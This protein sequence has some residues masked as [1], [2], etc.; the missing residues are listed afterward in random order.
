MDFTLF[1]RRLCDAAAGDDVGVRGLFADAGVYDVWAAGWRARLAEETVGTA[2]RVAGMRRVNPVY[3][4]RNHRVE[5]VIRAAVERGEFGPF[6]ELVEVV[7]RPYAE[8]AGMERYGAAARAE[9]VCAGD[10][11]RDLS[12]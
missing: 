6:A 2:E 4:P 3:I 9:G 10:V 1:F 7:A 5:A 12:C 11:L 8:K